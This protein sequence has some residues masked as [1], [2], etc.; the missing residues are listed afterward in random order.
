MYRNIQQVAEVVEQFMSYN[1]FQIGVKSRRGWGLSNKI[2]RHI[3]NRLLGSSSNHDG[4]MQLQKR[5]DMV[6]IN[7]E[8]SSGLALHRKETAA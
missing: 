6:L 4:Y 7:D 8:C 2:R 3:R 1:L 5:R